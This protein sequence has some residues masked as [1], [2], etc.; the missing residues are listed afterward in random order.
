MGNSR[1]T[2]SQPTEEEVG[3]DCRDECARGLN[4]CSV[5]GQA[6]ETAEDLRKHELEEHPDEHPVESPERSGRRA[7]LTIG[8]V[9]GSGAGASLARPPDVVVV[10]TVQRCCLSG[11][12]CAPARTAA[13]GAG[14]RYAAARGRVKDSRSPRSSAIADVRSGVPS[15]R[16][17]ATTAGRPR[18]ARMRSTEVVFNGSRARRRPKTPEPPAIRTRGRSAIGRLIP[19]TKRT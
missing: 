12:S 11:S 19:S 6:F 16:Q 5:C 4:V 13:C 9:T 7:P 17:A 3:S 15:S 8:R 14:H 18:P 10:V 1:M 2:Q